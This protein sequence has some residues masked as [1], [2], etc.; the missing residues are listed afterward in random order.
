MSY[1]PYWCDLTR[2]E[3]ERIRTTPQLSGLAVFAY[4]QDARHTNPN[5]RA[6]ALDTPVIEFTTETSPTP[7]SPR[8]TFQVVWHLR[9]GTHLPIALRRVYHPDGRIEQLA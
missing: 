9:S 1:G 5:Q 6:R 7:V 8:Q 2:N 4:T 3:L